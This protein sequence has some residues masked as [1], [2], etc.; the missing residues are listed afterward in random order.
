MI[1]DV[2]DVECNNNIDEDE[3]ISQVLD[4]LG[5]VVIISEGHCW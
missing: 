4:N 1:D 3:D 5:K 2:N